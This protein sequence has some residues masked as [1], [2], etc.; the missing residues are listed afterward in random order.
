MTRAGRACRTRWS[1][2]WADQ[3]RRRR[4][5]TVSTWSRRRLWQ[6]EVAMAGRNTRARWARA[7]QAGALPA[8]TGV[9]SMAGRNWRARWARAKPE[10]AAGKPDGR[11]CVAAGGNG[12][13]EPDQA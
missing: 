13:P 7:K 8:A 4:S 1:Q 6:P 9:L 11:G 2:L 12:E 5:R 3:A 10:M